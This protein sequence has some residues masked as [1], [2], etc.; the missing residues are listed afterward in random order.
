MS[1]PTYRQQHGACG[2]KEDP[3]CEYCGTDWPCEPALL[4]KALDA[5][6]SVVK[7]NYPP[8]ASLVHDDRRWRR[9]EK[10]V[11]DVMRMVE[12]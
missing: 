4:I 12:T 7:D 11:L 8:D 1:R 5:A 6:A 9:M 10:A 2:I 3:Y